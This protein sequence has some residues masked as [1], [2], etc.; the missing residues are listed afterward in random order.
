MSIKMKNIHKQ[1]IRVLLLS[2]IMI[3]LPVTDATVYTEVPV[4]HSAK[5]NAIEFN[6][7]LDI[8][9]SGGDDNLTALWNTSSSEIIEYVELGGPVRYLGW[10]SEG[11]K[12]VAVTDN[13]T[14]LD[15]KLDILSSS[16]VSGD[17]ITSINWIGEEVVIGTASGEI[18]VDGE[19]LYK[20]D[21]NIRDIEVYDNIIVASTESSIIVIEDGKIDSYNFNLTIQAIEVYNGTVAY[22]QGSSIEMLNLTDGT[23]SGTIETDLSIQFMSLDAQSNSLAVYGDGEIQ[24]WDL[25]EKSLLGTKS[26][27]GEISSIDFSKGIV[28]T[29]D[30]AWPAITLL[31]VNND[32]AFSHLASVSYITPEENPLPFSLPITVLGLAL[33]VVLVK[34]KKTQK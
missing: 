10:N 25:T 31:Y 27:R 21:G 8:L 7:V 3:G 13:L 12:L 28:A 30:P 2:S 32:F 16:P 18:I 34:R 15:Q 23:L 5:V 33:I 4:V 29:T 6:P 22:S 17:S 11:S 14:I 9:A 19:A 24:I 1:F 20:G 26:D